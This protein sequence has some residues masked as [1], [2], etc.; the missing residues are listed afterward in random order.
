MVADD[1]SIAVAGNE[2]QN[3][4]FEFREHSKFAI[5]APNGRYLKGEQNG[6]LSA[7]GDEISN[8]TLWEY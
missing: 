5:K 3:F 1:A 2:P 8:A 7:N 4:R 6:S